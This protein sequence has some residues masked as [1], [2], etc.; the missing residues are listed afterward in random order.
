MD[1]H[2]PQIQGFFDIPVDHLYAKPALI[3]Y[4]REQGAGA[5]GNLTH[6]GIP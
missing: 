3:G 5:D 6:S 2:A 1:L 4:L